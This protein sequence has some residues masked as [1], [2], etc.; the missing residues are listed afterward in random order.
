MQPNDTARLVRKGYQGKTECC[1]R[2][3]GVMNTHIAEDGRTAEG[4]RF[5]EIAC[6]LCLDVVGRR[7]L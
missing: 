3:L 2:P 7:Y 5:Y 4:V 1:S 6:N